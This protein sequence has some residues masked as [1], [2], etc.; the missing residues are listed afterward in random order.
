MPDLHLALLV[1]RPPSSVAVGD[2]VFWKPSGPTSEVKAQYLLK[3]VAG[4]GGDRLTIKNRKVSIN[5][6][7][8]ATGLDLLDPER[9][10]P[11]AFERDEIIPAGSLFVIGTH[12]HS[13][14]SRY[15]GYLNV[16]QV[17]GKAFKVM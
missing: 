1:N 6:H 14:D 12:P 17:Q 9:A 15:W 13:F 16:R 10:D 11:L 2:Y 5:G 8:V 7:V 3:W 4:V